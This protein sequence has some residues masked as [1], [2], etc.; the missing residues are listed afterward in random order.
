MKESLKGFAFNLFILTLVITTLGYGLFWKVIP[1]L[2]F[3]LFPLVPFFV[4]T[5]TL[6]VHIYLVRASENNARKFTSRYLGAMGLKIF[7]Y[8]IFLAVF[9]ALEPIS[10]IPFLLSFLVS[11][12]CLTVMEVLAIYRYQKGT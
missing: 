8:I 2:Y 1:E 11:Y 10:A 4:F 9:L 5:V 6:L 3:P 7:I 12:A